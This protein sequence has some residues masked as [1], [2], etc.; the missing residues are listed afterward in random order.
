M[1][2]RIVRVEGREVL[3]SRGNPTVAVEVMLADGTVREALVPSGASTG[4]H[5]A[6]ELRDRDKKRFGGT[7]VLAA[8]RHVNREIADALNGVDERDQRRID[9]ALIAFDGTPNRQGWEPTPFWERRSPASARP[10]RRSSR[11]PTHFQEF[12]I[13]PT[14]MPTFRQAVV[15]SAVPQ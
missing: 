12:I 2:L 13:V 1:D 9:R 11:R 15:A 6:V 4:V 8:V 5:E 7:G 3:D 14:G 10:R